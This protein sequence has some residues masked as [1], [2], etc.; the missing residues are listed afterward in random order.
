MEVSNL[1]KNSRMPSYMMYPRFLTE[2]EETGL[3]T[4][5]RQGVCRPNRIY[6]NLPKTETCPNDGRKT[7]CHGDR[8]LSASKTYERYRNYQY[9]EDDSL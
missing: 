4:R 9:E 7:V 6:V 5:K 1:T 3:I 2:L 8:N